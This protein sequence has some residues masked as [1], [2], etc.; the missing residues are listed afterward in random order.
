ML[1]IAAASGGP[2][3]PDPSGDWKVHLSVQGASSLLTKSLSSPVVTLLH[4][5]TLR[6]VMFY[7]L[8]KSCL[9]ENILSLTIY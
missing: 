8:F 9:S 1:D 3:F 7:D 4:S 5:A 6:C 2:A